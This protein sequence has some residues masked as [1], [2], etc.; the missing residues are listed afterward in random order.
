MT[1]EDLRWL[2]GILVAGFVATFGRMWQLSAKAS[3]G[4]RLLHK[5]IDEVKR[6]YVRRDDLD[7]HMART[8]RQLDEIKA[9]QKTALTEIAKL[10]ART[11]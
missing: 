11:D 10:T 5:K 4:D 9:D 3:E 1:V 6:D 8:E 7:K 2:Y